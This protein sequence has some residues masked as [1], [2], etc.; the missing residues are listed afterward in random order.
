MNEYSF[1]S[2]HPPLKRALQSSIVMPTIETK[3]RAEIITELKKT[4]K[5]ED[6]VR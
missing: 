4:E 1:D 2:H 5:K 3:S 6:V